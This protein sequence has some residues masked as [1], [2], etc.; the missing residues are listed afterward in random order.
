MPGTPGMQ[1]E[2][3]ADDAA[4]AQR[5]A[6]FIAGEA[7][8]AVQQRGRFSFAV[9]GGRTPW[10]MLRALA[11]E[12]LP[13]AAVQLFQVD[14]RIAPAGSAERNLTHIRASLLAH[15]ALPAANL[16]AMPVE[17]TDLDAAARHYQHTV[18]QLAGRPAVLD[19]VHLGLGTDGHTA[20][21]VPGDAVLQLGSA[22][23]GV[24]ATY[25]GHRRMTLSYPLLNRARR[26]LWLVTG[27]EKRDMLA[28]LLA[29]DA[30][31]P[32]GR[33]D[34]RQAIVLRD[35]AAAGPA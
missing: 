26:V 32:A 3:L 2:T 10:L 13:W 27:G 33:V 35:R 25:M 18:Q 19:L 30:S 14:E 24:T 11:T 8:Q 29:S 20:S 9:S 22:D 12:D 17:A 15:A 5:A 34:A 6:A 7:R 21:L 1:V 23:V 4:V 16:H 31:I 28:R